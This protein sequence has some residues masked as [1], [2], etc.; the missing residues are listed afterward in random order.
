M[1]LLVSAVLLIMILQLLPER[2]FQR[3]R[4][5]EYL[6]EHSLRV[7]RASAL[8]LAT[9]EDAETAERGYLL[10][11]DDRHLDQYQAALS[12]QRQASQNLRRLTADNSR[13]G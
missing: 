2:D 12:N 7:L 9:I 1:V 10:T 8:L 11:G 6:V 5:A 3:A 4:A 13:P